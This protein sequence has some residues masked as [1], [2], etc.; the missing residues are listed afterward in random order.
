MKNKMIL[1]SS[2][3]VVKVYKK[4]IAIL[5]LERDFYRALVEEKENTNVYAVIY[6]VDNK[7]WVQSETCVGVFTKKSK[8]ISSIFD[9]YKR[10]DKLAI[11]A[12]EILEYSMSKALHKND[13]VYVAEYDEESHGEV[14]TK[15][16]DIR[17]DKG[18]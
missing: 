13:I 16:R 6:C 4:R 17:C 2:T 11:D 15:I 10:N 3:D 9:V 12:F 7:E 18:C 1:S 8:A 5:T 14:A